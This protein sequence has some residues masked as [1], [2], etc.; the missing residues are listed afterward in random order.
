MNKLQGFIITCAAT[1][2]VTRLS[3]W[4]ETSSHFLMRDG[5]AQPYS[6]TL[7][8]RLLKLKKQTMR[9]ANSQPWISRAT[10]LGVE[11]NTFLHN[12]NPHLLHWVKPAPWKGK[13]LSI[14][15]ALLNYNW[16][17]LR[18]VFISAPMKL[19]VCFVTLRTVAFTSNAAVF[20]S[21]T[22]VQ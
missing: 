2:E 9:A 8:V 12:L 13:W 1:V 6:N 18:A 11:C 16:I 17:Y 19:N 10:F 5:T 14:F 22:A 4:T 20:I 7:P 15:S 21:F 3:P